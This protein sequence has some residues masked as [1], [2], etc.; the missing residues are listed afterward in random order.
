MPGYVAF[1]RAVSPMNAKMPAR[2]RCFESAG[3]SDVRTVISSGNVAFD[4]D[5]TSLNHLQRQAENAML[6]E[7]GRVTG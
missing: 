7:L 1:L 3:F 6:L 5:A 2:K 4:A